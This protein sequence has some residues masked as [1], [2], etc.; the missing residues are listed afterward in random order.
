[1]APVGRGLRDIT[2]RQFIK[3]SMG[4]LLFLPSGLT[5][6]KQGEWLQRNVLGPPPALACPRDEVSIG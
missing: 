3:N 6:K 2:R 5:I 1:M 4:K